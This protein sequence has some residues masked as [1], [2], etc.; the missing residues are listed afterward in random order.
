MATAAHKETDSGPLS[1]RD[2]RIQSLETSVAT[3]QNEL[4][5]LKVAFDEFRQQFQ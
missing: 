5:E 3:L 4:T 1:S 2:A